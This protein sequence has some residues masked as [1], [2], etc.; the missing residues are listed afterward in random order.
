[1]LDPVQ[2]KYRGNLGTLQEVADRT[3]HSLQESN[4]ERFQEL[5]RLERPPISSPAF[6]RAEPQLPRQSEGHQM[7]SLQTA[8]LLPAN[9]AHPR[10]PRSAG[11][12]FGS[13][14]DALGPTV[15]QLPRHHL[16][17]VHDMS[18]IERPAG[19]QVAPLP[20]SQLPVAHFSQPVGPVGPVGQLP[21]LPVGHLTVI[22]NSL[23]PPNL[24]D[25]PTLL[26]GMPHLAHVSYRFFDFGAAVWGYLLLAGQRLIISC[27]EVPPPPTC[28]KFC[29]T[30]TYMFTMETPIFE[31]I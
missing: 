1:M 3:I 17:A 4:Q 25:D 29:P 16:G 15:V 31:I 26:D 8:H 14:P 11:E 28:Q 5:Q 22:L 12:M 7:V 9:P 18:R 30:F 2:K 13:A 20:A 23:F 27:R 21:H 24:G 6:S 10:D 19:P